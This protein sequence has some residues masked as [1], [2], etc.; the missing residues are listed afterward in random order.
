MQCLA[1]LSLFLLFAVAQVGCN[2]GGG[3]G[4]AVVEE[5]QSA[6]KS[7][8][9]A[10]E[11]RVIATTNY[12]LQAITE[13]I[14]G[15]DFNVW[16]PTVTQAVPARDQLRKL[17]Q[18]S[19]VFTNGPGA[20]FSPWL[21]LVTIDQDKV[22]ETTTDSFELSDFIQVAEH[23]IVHSHGDEGEHSHPWMV[24]HCWLDPRL[25]LLQAEAVRD[26]LSQQ[27]P[28]YETTFHKNY[29]QSLEEPL[30]GLIQDN[31]KL[32]RRLNNTKETWVLSDPRL[33]FFAR[34]LK[35]DA[36][37]MLWFDLPEP[38]LAVDQLQEKI[39]DKKSA[40]EVWL[41]WAQDHG[42][43][44]DV[45]GPVA[46]SVELDLI[47]QPL[48]GQTFLVRLRSNFDAVAAAAQLNK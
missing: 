28:A 21:D 24:P 44:K 33:M 35:M 26:R 25:V 1:T 31:T 30:L 42:P 36:G 7:F 22:F 6:S 38:A 12:P 5:S 45:V 27:Y 17:Q 47:E 15:Q 48:P 20:D 37:H 10:G 34:S 14:A 43:L 11:E 39:G 32:T 18:S 23:Q 13:L 40:G 9:V 8:P 4:G 29:L 46:R 41:L 19:G 16:C 3:N 2:G